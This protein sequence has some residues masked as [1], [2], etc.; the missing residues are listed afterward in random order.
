MRVRA[1]KL[2]TS[3]SGDYH[4]RLEALEDRWLPSVLTV[5]STSD[6]GAGSLRAALAAANAG[7]D[8]VFNL[9]NPST[10]ILTSGPLVINQV[11]QID[12]TDPANLT[13]EVQGGVF[14]VFTVTSSAVAK[15]TGLTITG[16]ADSDG[17]GI[18]SSASSLTLTNCVFTFNRATNGG[19]I[20]NNGT[21]TINGCTIDGNLATIS[22]GILNNG[23]LTISHSVI[24]NNRGGV[25]GGI[26]QIGS[27]STTTMADCMITGNSA[28]QDSSGDSGA[29]IENDAGVMTLTRCTVSGNTLTAGGGAFGGGIYNAGGLTLL[30]SVVAGNSALGYDSVYG[31]G[32]YNTLSGSLIL[33]RSTVSGNQ[34][35]AGSQSSTNAFGGGIAANSGT[36]AVFS[37][38]V[39]GN[40]AF[41]GDS[42][43]TGGAANGGGISADSNASLTLNDS[44]I[45]NNLA[46]GGRSVGG[47][48]GSGFGG[49]VQTFLG[50][51][52]TII[53]C[54]VAGNIAG[55]GTGDAGNGDGFGGGLW[56]GAGTIWNSI[57]ATN[58]ASTSNQDL[59]VVNSIQAASS[60]FGV[61]D[62]SG[63]SNGVN[64]N[65][66]GTA[67]APLDPQLGPLQNNGG[68]TQ[69]M[70]LRRGSP[71]I[72]HGNNDLLTTLV[73]QR[74]DNRVVNDI[75]DMGAF[76]FQITRL[77]AVGADAGGPPEVKVYDASTGKRQF[78]FLAFNANFTGGVR[79]AVGDVN[80]DGVPDIIAAAG[81]GGGPQVN[82]YE[83]ATGSLIKSFNAYS[84]GFHGGVFV[85]AGDVNNDGYADVVTGADAG[86]GP[87]VEI[88]DGKNL[89]R[90]I[91]SRLAGFF[92]YDPT[93]TGG[94][95]IAVGD[96]NGDSFA[97]VVVGKG[98]GAAPR[99]RVFDGRQLLASQQMLLYDF[100]AFS[101][102]FSGGVYVA[103]G[104]VNGDGR[105]DIVVGKG[106]AAAPRV[107]VYTGADGSLLQSFF[108]Y[109]SAFGGGV[110]VAVADVDGD[111]RM[112]IITGAGPGGGPH[113][114]VFDGRTG[115]ALN[116]AFDS[117]Y[118]FG[119][120]FSGGVFVGGA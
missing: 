33:F 81:P 62:G 104:D 36:V 90:G 85:A 22:G 3:R 115:Q 40:S 78:D 95:R 102:T 59:T 5:T 39:S 18:L 69:T 112:E 77:L 63:V 9:P 66:V 86:G 108:A 110:R 119:P 97:D 65:L 101:T 64:G 58:I 113:V 70:A 75:T 13:I 118:A 44:T 14:R 114:R 61:G 73:D 35:Q 38:T 30:D 23:T 10:I 48:G 56:I 87:D 26:A 53:N 109:N 71:A 106:P 105:A 99:V 80:G 92:A 28:E 68:P 98:P 72:D 91:K 2:R 42:G 27:A 82:V 6:S 88:F 4:P 1:S 31:G 16:G 34:A 37:S 96:V 49:G 116:D 79:V 74:G 43:G 54:T 24:F 29:G 7:D 89:G 25:T 21:M 52:L 32:I 94:V 50:T 55:G 8:I 12:G 100:M 60:L 51:T 41:G 76:E 67:A 46:V 57:I 19:A 15:L 84:I 47:T 17:G 93:F 120:N 111:G 117:F 11:V 107:N 20:R 83:G 45:A 103:A